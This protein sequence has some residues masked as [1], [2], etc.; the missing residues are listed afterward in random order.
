M[1]LN[2]PFP[3]ED[4]PNSTS[5]LSS[6]CYYIT[7]TQAP[8]NLITAST[9]QQTALSNMVTSSILDLQQNKYAARNSKLVR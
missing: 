7:Q 9:E 6:V 5:D 4:N 8:L 3:D 1:I 2:A